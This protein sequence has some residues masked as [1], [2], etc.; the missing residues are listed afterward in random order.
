[1]KVQ[2]ILT[3]ERK[4]CKHFS[5]IDGHGEETLL[6][7]DAA[8]FCLYG[9]IEVAY[10]DAIEYVTRIYGGGIETLTTGEAE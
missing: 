7:S 5:A 2:D 3:S 1:M 10:G 9:A 4:W 6:N 8:A